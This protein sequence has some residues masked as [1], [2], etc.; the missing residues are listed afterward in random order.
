M[1][2][3][4]IFY[5]YRV[6]LRA[7]F[8]QEL[9]AVAGIAVGVALLFASQ[10]ANTSLSGSV[11]RLTNGLVGS[12]RLQLAARDPHGFGESL[13]SQVEQLRGVRSAVPVL[14]RGAEVIGP[15]GEKSVDLI[16]LD[17]GFVR[18]EGRLLSHVSA[19]QL[20]RQQGV[21]LPAPVAREIG[22][23]ALQAVSIHVGDMSMRTLTAVILQES[24]IGALVDSRVAISP[25]GLAQ[26]LAGMRGRVSRILV[27]PQPGHDRE[28]ERG[29]ERVAAGRLNVLP[30]NFEAAI[31][32]QAEAPTA[33]STQMFS[34]ISALVGFLFAFNAMLLTVP[35]RRNLIADL[36]LDGY[37]PGEILE[38]MLFDV[39]ALGVVGIGCGLALGELLSRSLLQADPGYLSLAFPVQSLHIVSWENVAVAA[40][41][42]FV[43]AVVGVMVP[44]RHEI[45]RND[46]VGPRRPRQSGQT[47]FTAAL[48][49]GVGCIAVTTAILIHGITSVT[50][51][52]LGFASLMLGLLLVMPAAF[53]G[54]VSLIN[55]AQRSVMGVSSRIALIEL[56]SST[57]RSRSLAIAATGA[58]AVFGCVAIE[59]AR[60][61]LSTGLSRAASDVSLG[62]D[63]WVSP[64]GSATTLAT[65]PFRN[66]YGG[67]LSR[68]QTVRSVGAYRGGFLDL[69]DRRVLVIAPPKSDTRLFPRSQVISGD[70]NVA[71]SRILQGGWI[72]V[73]QTLAD[74]HKLG[75]GRSL[76]LASPRPVRFRVAAIVTNL[77]WAPGAIV[78]NP[79]DYARA[80]GSSDV[81]AY[82]VVL[83]TGVPVLRG[84]R[85][86]Q[87]ALRPRSDL[88]VQT[89]ARH[90]Q[91]DLAAQ[92][93]G[94][95]RLTQIAALVLV[96]AALA[97]AAAMGA[98]IWQRRPRLAGM[99]V[100]GFSQGELWCALLW[101]TALLLGAG[102]TI[103]AVFGLYGQ[104]VLSQAL[105]S[106]TGFPVVFS[107][108]IPVAV[109]SLAIISAIA[110]AMVAL[111]GYF[112]AQVKPALQD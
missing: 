92:R 76:T 34:A 107:V 55:R 37:T 47:S 21:A 18:L 5:L 3:S 22:A 100:D 99:K 87:S 94:L 12:A 84:L 81:S 68:L 63:L 54:I 51:A 88:V 13:L 73:S 103:G 64:A 38:V 16:G 65:T 45:F 53:G 89:A 1:R 49:G 35:Q 104:L 43:A 15:H 41:G 20:P 10:V 42:G 80:W 2:L 52:I 67:L 50:A 36:R 29:L 101:E 39:L 78:M 40:A 28:V 23:G 70:A 111:P 26:R 105:V 86:V 8:V 66:V 109:V 85:E 17:A 46:Q 108:A 9:L 4:T 48:I 62:T 57:S 60:S 30:A 32:R 44:L 7:R 71:R 75:V 19:I 79:E 24:D 11:T 25:L 96:A 90:R 82:Q 95:A 102:C 110:L 33:Q 69:G 14:Q 56:M 91:N 61:D 27:E 112:A 77:G 31:F 72:A 59:G 97:M 83:K 93:Q 58:I 106:V 6:R 98:M 74:E